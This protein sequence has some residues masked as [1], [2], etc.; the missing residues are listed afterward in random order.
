MSVDELRIK[1]RYSEGIVSYEGYD[2]AQICKNGHLI[3]RS[4]ESDETFREDF[5]RKCGA[6]TITACEQCGQKIRGRLHGAMPSAHPELVAK[7]CFKCGA[8]YPWT[9]KAIS[10]TRELLAES[11]LSAPEQ[12]L[13]SKSL[14]DIVRDTP[15]TQV[16]AARFKKFLPKAGK[17]IAEGVRSLVVDI[18]SEAA[19]KILWPS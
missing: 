2:T 4:A 1:K 10:A 18:A 7:F 11:A 14:D 17:E 13:M 5:C 6:K 3:T 16:A 9:A 15:A 12:E 8:P 19:K